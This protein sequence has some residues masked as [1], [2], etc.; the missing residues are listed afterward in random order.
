MLG[1]YYW[2]H[3]HTRSYP[4]NGRSSRGELYA[5][6]H[7]LEFIKHQLSRLPTRAW[8]SRTLLLATASIWALLGV[9]GLSL[10]R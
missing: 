1:G 10:T 4:C 7:D 2:N 8:L 5:I 6:A 9:L 3:L